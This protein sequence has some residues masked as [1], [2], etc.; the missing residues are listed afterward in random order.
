[1]QNKL[2]E[3]QIFWY[4]IKLHVVKALLLVTVC[5]AVIFLWLD[6]AKMPVKQND[7]EE[8]IGNRI[9]EEADFAEAKEDTY[10]FDEKND[11]NSKIAEIVNSFE[12]DI[13]EDIIEA[14]PV[15]VK[16]E[17]YE[18]E[19]AETPLNEQEV[20]DK[21]FLIAI[22]IDDMG[23]NAENSKKIIDL[24][25]KLTA[26]FL[27]YGKNLREFI[28]SAK[29]ERK[30]VIVHI[31][32]EPYSATNTAPNQLNVAMSDNEIKKNL[33]LVLDNFDADLIGGNNHMG[34][35]FTENREKLV[36]VM[37]ILKKRGMFFLDSKTSAKA[38]GCEVAEEFGVE[39]VSRD[40]FLDNENDFNYITGQLQQVEKIARKKGYAIA[41]GHPKSQT[42]EALR[43]WVA[44][45][46]KQHFKLVYL[47][48]I[49]K[50]IRK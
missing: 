50:K 49:L 14:E 44:K 7:E 12:P 33:E 42:V 6:Y 48:E 40:V 31:P 1:M 41:I 23:I 35:K 19:K 45:L 17:P 22:V 36:P 3:K 13:S 2:S 47:S 4:K 46:D 38:I 26:S 5:F 24:K 27:T 43:D 8:H 9:E 28:E 29:A 32:M 20:E 34:S 16:E 30:E 39:C 18:L 21:H 15:V 11:L 37:K 10:S 25:A